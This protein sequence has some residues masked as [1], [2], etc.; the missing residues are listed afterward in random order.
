MGRGSKI[1]LVKLN[2]NSAFKR[3]Y[4]FVLNGKLLDRSQVFQKYKI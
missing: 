3:V 2:I 4:Y 1:A